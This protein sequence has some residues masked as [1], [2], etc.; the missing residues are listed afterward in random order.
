MRNMKESYTGLIKKLFK[1]A[2][3]NT[4]DL[5]WWLT[6]VFLGFV[7]VYPSFIL[8]LNSF[9]TETG[10]SLQ[11]YMVVFRDPQIIKSMVNSM[12][13]VIPS[14]IIATIIGVFLAWIVVRTN[15]PGKKYWKLLLSIPYFLPPFIGAIAWTFLLGPVGYFNKFFMSVFGLAKPLFNVYTIEGMVFVMSLYRYAIP[16]IVVL[17]TMEKISASME[18]AARISG[19]STWRTLKDITI[20]LITPSTLGAMLL[21]FMFILA[22]FGV[23]AVLGAPNQIRLMTTQIYYLVSRPDMAN[24]LQIASAYSIFLAMFGII[25]LRAYNKILKTSKYA[26]ISGKSAAVEPTKFGKSK[27]LFFGFLVIFF[28][29]TTLAPILATLVTSLTKVYGLP[30]GLGN[31]TTR[32]FVNMLKIRNV[33]R[34]FKN[35]LFL[36][37]TSAILITIV[38]MIVAYIASGRTKKKMRG[39]GLM[40]TMVTIPYA[41]PG[42]IIAI[43]MI[44]S[45]ARPLPIVNI[46]L[47][48]TIWILLIA[49]VARFMN[50]G[51]NNISGAISQ[52]DPS[53]EEASRISGASHFRSFMDIVFPILKPSLFASLLLV[54]APTLSEITLSS[55]LW[56]VNNETIG[57]IVFSAQEEGKILL[58]ASIAIVL[59]IIVIAINIVS[60]YFTSSERL[61][62]KSRK[63][64]EKWEN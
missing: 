63:G 45:F 13:V 5:I 43:A 37:V 33:A 55:L 64:M 40:Q 7:V 18:E 59:M 36:A 44:L 35:S 3:E 60:H 23:S 14:T 42:T 9:K 62:K 22:D 2:G 25:G 19:A 30:F 41:V 27:W 29:I 53:L 12:K 26:V 32:N 24:N 46:R 48:R 34:A 4:L 17:P 8:I 15:V 61:A 49:Y 50:L 11:N 52:I 20:P 58:T 54:I 21:L 57:T 1:N 39:L 16:F 47:Y 56:S 28:S 10:Y 31:I 38:T 6:V 51:Y